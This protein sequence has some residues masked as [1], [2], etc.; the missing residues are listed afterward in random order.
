MAITE[1]GSNV[2]YIYGVSAPGS[3]TI[4]GGSAFA[5]FPDAWGAL[6]Y[7]A[8]L[9]GGGVGLI[10]VTGIGSRLSAS[11][12]STVFGA[13]GVE[14]RG[15]LSVGAGAVAAFNSTG[16]DVS[17][18]VGRE[19]GGMG[20]VEIEAG[21]LNLAASNG[22][23]ELVVS[24]DDGSGMVSILDGG[25]IRVATASNSDL[26][27]AMVRLGDRSSEV[28][29]LV[30]SDGTLELN[31]SSGSTAT[32]EV[33]GVRGAGDLRVDAGGIVSV[34][35]A[36]TS[37]SR[38]SIGSADLSSGVATITGT[39][40][41]VTVAGNGLTTVGAIASGIVGSG[42]LD[43]LNGGALVSD[44]VIVGVG[45][46]ITLGTS[47]VE[48]ETF[49]VQGGTMSILAD[50]TSAVEGDVTVEAGSTL[51]YEMVNG[52]AGLLDHSGGTFTV[53]A[54][55]SVQLDGSGQTFAGGERLTLLR[56]DTTP[57]IALEGLE[58]V[59]QASG[60]SHA[61]GLRTVAGEVELQ[62]E[63]LNGGTF[64]FDAEA[65]DGAVFSAATSLGSGGGYAEVRVIDASRIEGTD[66]ADTFTA[67]SNAANLVG[68][69][70]DDALTGGDGDDFLNGG[71][72]ADDLVGGGGVDTATYANASQG[73]IANL[74]AGG[75]AGE[76]TGDTYDGVENIVGSAF[77]DA[78]L[79]DD[80]ANTLEGGSGNDFF[81]ARGGA[82]IILGGA[83]GD[84][85]E[86]G[87]GADLL[88]GGADF[89]NAFYRSSSGAVTVD[90]AAG[91][92][93]GGHAEGDTYVSIELTTGSFFA[94]TLL[95][96][97]GRN[98]LSGGAGDDVLDGRGG[99]DTMFGSLGD[100]TF[101]FAASHGR[102]RIID[103]KSGEDVLDYSDH[104]G[105]S[106]FADLTVFDSG[107]SAIVQD[108]AGGQV[109]LQDAAGQV[110]A[111]DFV[112]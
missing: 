52:A 40:S 55:A 27:G 75:S 12:P 111:S 88:D 92:G 102:D 7:G 53:V 44:H 21:T 5:F 95:G 15:T 54:S 91:A 84:R 51:T 20:G 33:G 93:S 80:V 77:G 74:V 16:S 50:G 96:T 86:G 25:V 28:A 46:A 42:S 38:F 87:A 49:T 1:S 58:L 97:A 59:G 2:G 72:G 6:D 34:N 47:T 110:D 68:L 22:S 9:G 71:F 79:G 101:V 48:S 103:F 56:T 98:G 76:A 4:N 45:G 104:T 41:R 32:L 11:V 57:A 35:G 81:V 14:A 89:D 43:I 8:G 112:F 23:A 10:D 100:D 109:V 36:G 60:F 39:G 108:D 70:G 37:Q 13:L 78:L 19:V 24:V 106:S 73:V 85:L 61:F 17:L 65:T 83:G 26:D 64:A 94:D 99:N 66:V 67:G 62:F 31:A 82:D 3:L 107:T 69:G 63:A 18:I 30:V 29:N 90:L 105:V